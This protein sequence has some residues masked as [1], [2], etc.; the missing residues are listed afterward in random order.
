MHMTRGKKKVVKQTLYKHV[1]G[2][3]W[4]LTD[5]MNHPEAQLAKI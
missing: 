4:L 1:C 5:N 2:Y 3:S